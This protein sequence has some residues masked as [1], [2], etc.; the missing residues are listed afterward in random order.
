MLRHVVILIGLVGIA[1]WALVGASDSVARMGAD[2]WEWR[3]RTAPFVADDIPRIERPAGA[4]HD[5]SGAGVAKLRRELA[6]FEARWKSLEGHDA[7]DYRLMGSALARVHW[8]LDVLKR[9]QR[10]PNFYIEQT[11]TPLGEA[12]TV[13]APYDEG[14]SR[15]ILRRLESIPGTVRE[16]E[17]TL[18]SPPAPFARLAMEELT[19]VRAKLRKVVESLPPDTTIPAAEWKV[20]GER[21][22]VALEQ[23]RQWLQGALPKLPAQAA[24]GRDKYVWFLRNVALIP[25]QPEELVEK[26]ELELRRSVVFETYEANRNVAAAP[27]TMAASTGELVERNRKGEESIREFVEQHGILTLP[28]WLRHYTLRPIPAYLAA[29]GDF[30]ETDDFTS[31]TRLDRDGIRYVAAPSANA[32]YFAVSA[33]KDPRI[34]VVHEGTV[35]HYG[36]LCLSWKNPDPLRRHYYDSSANE[37]IGFYAEEMMLQEGLYDESPHTREIVYNQMR[38]RALRVIVDVKV[39]LG[40]MSQEEAAEFLMRNAPMNAASARTE[41]VEMNEAPG[42]K[43]SYQVG[44]L[45]IME[46]LAAARL[47]EGA[48]FRLRR[49]H[50]FVW[51]N[52]N[53]PIA[54]QRLEYLGK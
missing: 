31:G 40:E 13:P 51:I 35:G 27:L 39:A 49:F 16:A 19:E 43:I 26:A 18:V 20:A 21:A 28:S 12:L 36:Q 22:G 29:L 54:L 1:P 48:E 10:D 2:F 14:R 45:Q 52:G 25:D 37:G 4:A 38:L 44:K 46:M 15:E 6:G 24:I 23:F 53:V 33:A 8:E 42:Q 3:G 7:V 17:R 34:Q 50:D 41:V 32:S 30:V 11:L 5:W 47:K 9:W